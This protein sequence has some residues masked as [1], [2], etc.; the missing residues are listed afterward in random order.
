MR[1]WLSNCAMQY[2]L[3]MNFFLLIFRLSLSHSLVFL[4]YLSHLELLSLLVFSHSLLFLLLRCW[5][6]F[7]LFFVL[8]IVISS[9]K[10]IISFCDTPDES[11][12][13]THNNQISSTSP[14]NSPISMYWSH[15]TFSFLSNIFLELLH[16]IIYVHDFCL[17][18][19]IHPFCKSL[20][21]Q[22]KPD[23]NRTI[24]EGSAYWYVFLLFYLST[25]LHGVLIFE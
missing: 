6:G 14:P 15:T 21:S 4:P 7:R 9:H 3:S 2:A 19:L 17:T 13:H 24:L 11:L 20:F 12:F 5:D 23:F 10:L 18:L 8:L 1:K 25:S 16:T 22:S